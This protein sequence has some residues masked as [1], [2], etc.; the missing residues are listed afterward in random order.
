MALLFLFSNKISRC[1]FSRQNFSKLV[2]VSS[3][4][5]NTSTP[6]NFPRGFKVKESLED[7]KEVEDN[8]HQFMGRGDKAWDQ[9][10]KIITSFGSVRVDSDNVALYHGQNEELDQND[11]IQEAPLEAEVKDTGP[12]DF[13]YF[14]SN[15][16][17][18]E[19]GELLD[20]LFEEQPS[21][22]FFKPRE[23]VVNKKIQTENK[24]FLNREQSKENVTIPIDFDKGHTQPKDSDNEKVQKYKDPHKKVW[25]DDEMVLLARGYALL[26]I[27]HPNEGDSNMAKLLIEHHHTYRTFD[28]VRKVFPTEKFKKILRNVRDEPPKILDNTR[29]QLSEEDQKYKD[30]H[31]KEVEDLNYFDSV[32]FGE[33]FKS[34]S[35]EVSKQE[36]SVKVDPK[37]LDNTRRQLSEEDLNEID[38]EFFGK[39][40]DADDKKDLHEHFLSETNNVEN[41]AS[42]DVN[43]SS[44]EQSD[45]NFID[46]QFFSVSSPSRN[47]NQSKESPTLTPF[48]EN[49]I[50]NKSD[51]EFKKERKEKRQKLKTEPSSV[52]D[53]Q[54]ENIKKPKSKKEKPSPALDYVRKLRKSSTSNTKLKEPSD[55]IGVNLQAR[56]NAVT[57]VDQPKIKSKDN[58]ESDPDV[59]KNH[60]LPVTRFCPP[61]LDQYTSLELEE[62]LYSK[63]I[64]DDHDIVAL[65]KPYGLSMFNTEQ[66]LVSNRKVFQKANH[67]VEKYLPKLAAKLNCEKLYE[68][69]RLDRTTTGVVILAR[70]EERRKHLKELF[71]K[72]KISK[73]YLALVN[74]TPHPEQGIINIPISDGKIGERFRKT[75]RPDYAKST[76]ITNKKNYKGNVS[77]AAT[78]YSTLASHGSASLVELKMLSGAKHQIRIHLGLGLGTPVLGDHKYSYADQLG[79]PQ[80]VAGDIVQRLKIKRSRTRDLPIFLHAKSIHIPEIFPERDLWINAKLPHFYSKALRTLK[81]KNAFD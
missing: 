32:A 61:N 10:S 78:E 72:K 13:K 28:S 4:T 27:I 2:L 77:P 79:K 58:F 11:D 67:S 53:S 62:L 48:H 22:E 81:I 31:K 36:H 33:A 38:K 64:Y 14:R 24:P 49:H 25:S 60:Y 26:E 57:L 55:L 18:D 40:K 20:A 9:E 50:E 66:D 69:H 46:E 3:R 15:P 23:F 34:F 43:R 56:L 42:K 44:D 54:D 41:T 1:Y 47:E 45:L 65:W 71:N 76:V 16:K 52:P 7:E 80:R 74:G 63:I 17:S 68:V 39:S 35:S 59:E 12:G 37:I 6:Q 75:L 8:W 19:K 30:P 5:L 73:T 21:R 70:T 51:S 29:R